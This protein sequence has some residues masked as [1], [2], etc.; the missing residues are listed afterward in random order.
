M[1][2][3]LVED[4]IDSVNGLLADA[5]EK[6]IT[7]AAVKIWLDD[8]KE[9]VYEAD[10]LLDEIAYKALQ[11]KLEPAS[12]DGTFEEG[13][14]SCKIVN[15]TRHFSFAKSEYGIF[16]NFPDIYEAKHLR[17]FIY[18]EPYEEATPGRRSSIKHEV[19]H[20]LL[21]TLT[22]LRVLSL[23]RLNMDGLVDS[24]RELR[25]LKYLNLSGTLIESLPESIKQ[26]VFLANFNLA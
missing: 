23:P 25:Q 24:I 19:T 13:D 7:Q 26:F 22:R 6:Q 3:G 20:G 4:N 18:M 15:R 16:N 11:S 1:A 9:A 17:T 8:L 10:D 2:E 5:E 21:Q 14:N 12:R